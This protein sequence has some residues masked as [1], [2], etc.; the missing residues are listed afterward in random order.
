MLLK[1]CTV[2]CQFVKT[3]ELLRVG[4]SLE[5]C[6]HLPSRRITIV[7]KQ[8]ELNITKTEETLNGSSDSRQKTKMKMK[9]EP[10]FRRQGCQERRREQKRIH[11]IFFARF[12]ILRTSDQVFKCSVASQ[13]Q[14]SC[15]DIRI[16][17]KIS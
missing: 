10:S 4:P 14:L 8:T 6:K 15:R 17:Q 7:V 16:P 5:P 11:R 9:P 2:S 1:F 12:L 13:K 3:C